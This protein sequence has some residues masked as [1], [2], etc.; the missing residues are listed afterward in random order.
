MSV[1]EIAEQALKSNKR[2]QRFWRVWLTASVLY[3]LACLAFGWYGA[4]ALTLVTIG[5]SVWQL[6][7]VIPGRIR[8]WEARR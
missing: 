6:A 2:Y 3:G 7:V 8:Y 4:A 1:T 5:I